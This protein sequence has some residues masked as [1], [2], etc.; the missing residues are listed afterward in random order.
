MFSD[1]QVHTCSYRD[2]SPAQMQG[3]PV[4]NRCKWIKCLCVGNVL[5]IVLYIITETHAPKRIHKSWTLRIENRDLRST[6]KVLNMHFFLGNI[7]GNCKCPTS[8]E[9]HAAWDNSILCRACSLG[10]QLLL[11]G[12]QPGI[13][14]SPAGHV[15]WDIN[16]SCRTL[17]WDINLSCR[18]CS[19]GY[20]TLLRDM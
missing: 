14:T 11:Q 20:Q 19:M 17:A 10:Y 4:K 1:R 6:M 18:A 16:L 12:M 9:K 7:C 3:H 5:K 13:S 8:P 2:H 15:A